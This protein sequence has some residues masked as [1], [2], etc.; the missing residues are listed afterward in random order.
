MEFVGGQRAIKKVGRLP[1]LLPSR[2]L[3]MHVCM[4]IT[5]RR[6]IVA[7]QTGRLAIAK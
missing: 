7:R 4:W 5:Y 6:V 3:R 1:R 2:G